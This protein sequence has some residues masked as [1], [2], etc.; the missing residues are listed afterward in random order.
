MSQ[1]ERE[2]GVQHWHQHPPFVRTWVT[3]PALVEFIP[4]SG[5][6]WGLGFGGWAEEEVGEG[7]SKVGR[8]ISRNPKT[9]GGLPTQARQPVEVAERAHSWKP[10]AADILAPQEIQCGRASRDP[11]TTSFSRIS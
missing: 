7:A 6:G 9:S 11:G 2:I 4:W 5:G 3:R 1:R 8:E 10:T